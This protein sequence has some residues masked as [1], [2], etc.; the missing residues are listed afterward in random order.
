[1]ASF[2]Y[3]NVLHSD[4]GTSL[5]MRAKHAFS[6]VLEELAFR[7]AGR[8]QRLLRIGPGLARSLTWTADRA[9]PRVGNL[10]RFFLEWLAVD[11]V[12]TP[13]GTRR[14]EPYLRSVPAAR[15]F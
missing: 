9:S 14:L 1:M 4:Y 2:L 13:V 8:P 5:T 3:V 11:G 15:S 6:Q 10:A 7:V 12:G